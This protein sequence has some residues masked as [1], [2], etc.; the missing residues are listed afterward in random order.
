VLYRLANDGDSTR[1]WFALHHY[2][3]MQANQPWVM[4]GAEIGS[5]PVGP[6]P[7]G[8]ADWAP[9]SDVTSS[10]CQQVSVGIVSPVAGISDNVTQC[11]T[12]TIA[13]SPAAGTFAVHWDGRGKRATLELAMQI[14][15]SVPANGWPQWALPAWVSG[16]PF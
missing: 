12:W 8:W 16:S 2:A 1:D 3:T 4:N 13:K 6:T 15:V 10:G 11:E 14:A 7:Q 5:S 9:R